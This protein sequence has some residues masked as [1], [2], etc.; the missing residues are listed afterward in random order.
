MSKNRP[1]GLAR[2]DTTSVAASEG[3][4]EEKL[5]VRVHGASH[6]PTLIYLP[7]IH[8]NWCLIGGFRRA[9]GNRVRF[10]EV[11]YPGTLTWTL[12]DHAAA[13]ESALARHDVSNGWLLAESFGS[14]VA[15]S[16]L[17]RKSFELHALILAGGFV[18]HPFRGAARLA[19]RWCDDI[20]FSLL[21]RILFG[22]ATISRFRFR[23]SPETFNE[24]QEFINS[25]SKRELEAAKH[26]LH[27]IAQ[28]D[29]CS[30]ATDAKIP[31][32]AISGLF[33]PVVPWISVRRWLKIHCRALREYK[34]IW[35]ADHNVLGTAPQRA[36]AQILKWMKA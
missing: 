13:L 5:K 27:L 10:V 4:P 29:L 25:L 23:R 1:A 35:C 3:N 32:Y 6:L 9:L 30:I 31:V 34:I 15:W 18:G 33:D 36:S 2:E 11:T 21:R 19:Q 26:R 22:Y 28:S 14:Q 17:A 20:S 12:D 8:G 16:F 24:I 7:G